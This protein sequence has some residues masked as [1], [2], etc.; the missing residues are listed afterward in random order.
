MK[1]FKILTLVCT[2]AIATTS[3]ISCSDKSEK[4][5]MVHQA[6]A[7]ES[8]DECHLCGM[9]ITR[10]DGPKGELFRKEQGDKVFKFCSTRDMFSY[11]LDP[12][13]K[14]NV[15]Q[16]LVHDM[17]KM[18]WGS[19]SIDDKYFIDAKTAWYVTGSEKTGAMGQTLASFSQQNDAK[20]FAKE[21]GGIVVSFKDI[22]FDTLQ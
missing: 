22:S 10:F 3:L 17:S 13:N 8:S 9:L 21:F 15:S 2:L 7:M 6:V 5:Q 18:P 19:D 1:I 11:Y 20:A 4:T 16:M 12:E 14:R